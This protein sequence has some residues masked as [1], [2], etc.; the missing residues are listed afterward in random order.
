MTANADF[1]S[2]HVTLAPAARGQSTLH[3]GFFTNK[4]ML[5]SCYYKAHLQLLSVHSAGQ[6]PEHTV[7]KCS[8]GRPESDGPSPD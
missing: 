1:I 6:K 3:D 5:Q 4:V 7:W 2:D 8:S